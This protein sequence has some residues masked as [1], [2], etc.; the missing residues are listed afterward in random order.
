MEETVEA[1]VG[2]EGEGLPGDP[3]GEEEGEGG[4]LRVE[5]SGV[6]STERI[7]DEIGG[8]GAGEGAEGIAE[9]IAK[10][11]EAGRNGELERFEGEREEGKAAYD[12]EEGT[13]FGIGL[14]EGPLADEGGGEIEGDVDHD[15][16]PVAGAGDGVPGEG[17][18]KAVGVKSPGEGREMDDGQE[19]KSKQ[20]THGVAEVG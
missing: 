2:E 19:G 1:E 15:I 6:Y 12:E 11:G 9:Y 18:G 10:V 5:S 17:L 7:R 13:K 14:G 8:E 3:S 16:L 4:K 20:G